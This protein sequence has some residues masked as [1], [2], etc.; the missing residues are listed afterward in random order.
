M[1][2][3]PD[4]AGRRPRAASASTGRRTA[5]ASWGNGTPH[6]GCLPYKDDRM[7]AVILSKAMLLAKNTEITDPTILG[8]L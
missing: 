6:T 4:L 7:L 5:S 8:Q 3:R 2:E 1:G